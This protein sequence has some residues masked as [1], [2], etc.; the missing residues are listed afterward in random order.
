M[1][2]V[3]ITGAASGIG[4]A[5]AHALLAEG[6][7][8]AGCD[9]DTRALTWLDEAPRGLA[10][11]AD[12]ATA[13]GN[14]AAVAAAVARFGGLDGVVLNAG[15]TH[16]GPLESTDATTFDRLLAVNLRGVVL[17]LQAALPALARG[18]APAIVTVASISG[19]AGEPYMAAYAATKGG[20]IALT[21]SAAVELGARGVRVNCVCPGPTLTAMTQPALDATPRLGET[22]RRNVPLKRLAQPEE[23][24]AAIAFLLSPAAS[25]VHGV[26]LPVDGGVLANAGQQAPP[27]AGARM[28]VAA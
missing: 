28:E 16:V 23:I 21:R 1:R 6:A 3:L 10:V 5:T 25:F 20:V 18:D 17:G 15:V 26:V 7:S 11:A 13:D 14:A 9:V 2:R 22:L 12:V 8:V 4:R 19:L 27:E 24:A